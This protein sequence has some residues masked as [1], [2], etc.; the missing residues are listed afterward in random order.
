MQLDIMERVK[1]LE[2]L[3]PEGDLL[4]L[5]IVRKLREALSFS[6]EELKTFG[7]TDEYMCPYRGEDA[8][9]GK[10]VKCDNSGYFPTQP[11]CAEHGILMLPTGQMNLT[12]PPGALANV[13]EIHMGTQA[14][15]VASNALKQLNNQ[16]QLTDAHVSLYEKFFPP[17]EAGVPEAIEKSMG[18]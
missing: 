2:A 10:M 7:K 14:M 6:E 1:L 9:T 18:E 16:K 5:K 15:L 4:T 8:N 3:P 11:T 13:K 17:E 12:I